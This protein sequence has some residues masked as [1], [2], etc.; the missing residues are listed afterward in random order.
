MS[1][2]TAPHSRDESPVARQSGPNVG[3]RHTMTVAAAACAALGLGLASVGCATD[4]GANPGM[5][6]P[7][8]P[9]TKVMVAEED[10]QSALRFDEPIVVRGDDGFIRRVEVTVRAATNEPLKVDYRPYFFDAQGAAVRPE[11]SWQTEFLDPR[12]PERILL[13]PPGRNAVDYEVQFRWSR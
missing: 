12:V 10:L 3:R 8:L 5:V 9:Y 6:D 11:V 1:S 4:T 7:S 2:R 13:L